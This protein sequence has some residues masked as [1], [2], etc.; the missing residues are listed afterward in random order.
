MINDYDINE[1]IID[2]DGKEC[3]IYE[4]TSNSILVHIEKKRKEGINCNQWFTIE[5]FEKRFIK[6]NVI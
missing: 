4:K 2:S 6:K 1:K 5:S 3:I